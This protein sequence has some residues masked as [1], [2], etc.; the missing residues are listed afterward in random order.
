[1]AI[2]RR[3]AVLLRPIRG[4]AAFV[5]GLQARFQVALQNRL[6]AAYEIL[7]GAFCRVRQ[8]QHGVLGLLEQSNVFGL[9]R[10]TRRLVVTPPD[11]REIQPLPHPAGSA[12]DH[13]A[14]PRLAFNRQMS[15][16]SGV[17]CAAPE[18]H[19]RLP[20]PFAGRLACASW[21]HCCV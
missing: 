14:A 19:G 17:R 8:G 4:D 11:S 7:A 10:L 15:V 2:G 18:P 9:H 20:L 3:R 21:V 6:E 5:R 1:M 13:C 12:E 16:V